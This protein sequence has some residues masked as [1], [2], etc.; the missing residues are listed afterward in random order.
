MNTARVVIEEPQLETIGA[1]IWR[2]S[3]TIEGVRVFFESSVPL[4]PRPE[5][6]VSA[7]LLPAMQVHKD[8]ELRTPVDPVFFEHLSFIRNRAIEWW[9][10]LSG[11]CVH[12]STA[13]IERSGEHTGMFYS[14]G[15]DSSYVLQQKHWQ[16]RYAVFV[17]GYDTPLGDMKRLAAHR[18]QL[19]RTAKECGIALLS[20]KTNLR[21][22]PF[23]NQVNWGI[24]HLAALASVAHV[25]QAHVKTMYVAA[26]DIPPPWGSSPELDAA[27]S[28]SAVQIENFGADLTRLDRVRSIAKWER[29]RGRLRVCWENNSEDLNC[30]YCEKCIRSRLQLYIS[31][32][33]DG[34]GSFPV[35]YPLLQSLRLLDSVGDEG[36][37]LLGQWNEI[38]HSL[39]DRRLRAEV[40]RILDNQLP[41]TWRR[42]F[43]RLRQNI[44]GYMPRGPY[45]S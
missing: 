23:F 20:V 7:F 4:I 21:E 40:E 6:F 27:W 44:L 9:P 11:G 43:R 25:L 17:E 8:L 28:S 13:A 2:V 38:R 1:N 15:V 41:P 19:K 37:E 30:G 42:I 24:T 36:R 39:T 5:S 29:L 31:G 12:A 32:A 34:L 33:P 10:Q 26:S 3:A 16:V 14:G 45:S 18:E 35:R 22:H